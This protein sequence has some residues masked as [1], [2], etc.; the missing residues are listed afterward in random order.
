MRILMLTPYLPYPPASGGQIRTYNLLKHLS[1][2]HDIT[3]VSLYKHESERQF[4]EKLRTFCTAIHLC[5]RPEKPW[6]ITTIL[7]S[8]FGFLPFLVV[9]NYSQDAKNV[10]EELLREKSFDVIHAETF[11]IMPH[12]P[13]TST[14]IV[15]VEQTLEYRVYK[16][17]IGKLP[18]YLHH[19]LRLDIFKL[20][21]WEKHYWSKAQLVAAMSD[22]DAQ[23]ITDLAPNITPVVI[24]NGASDDMFVHSSPQKEGQ[25]PHILFVGN[26]SWLQ[27]TEAAEFLTENIVPLL[28]RKLPTFTITIAGQN[29][30]SILLQKKDKRI[31]YVSLNDANNEKVKSLYMD[32]TLFVAPIFGPGGTRLKILTSMATHLPVITTT[33]GAEGLSLVDGESVVIAQTPEEFAQAIVELSTHN[34]RRRIQAERAYE[35]A[36]EKFSWESITKK[37]VESYQ[38]IEQGRE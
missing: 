25:I 24:P 13:D 15:L 14:P 18:W 6:Q 5:K 36:K 22:S 23:A 37:L 38:S 34:E 12:I 35:I 19:P 27:N 20:K 2:H 32:A 26:F 11:Y 16:H 31:Q 3:L 8:V 28:E 9:R 29:I 33:T 4:A 10:V 30:P 7:K 21:V 17:Y 1:K